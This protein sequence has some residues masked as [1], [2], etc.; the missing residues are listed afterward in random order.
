[1][2]VETHK[3]GPGSL[4][5]GVGATEYSQQLRALSV[6]PSEN[7]TEEEDLEVLSGDTI[8]GED[9][10][11]H[12]AELSGKMLQDL[13]ADGFVAYSWANRGQ[14]VPFTYTPKS[15]VDAEVT[16]MVRLVPITIGGDVK[17][18]MESDFSWQCVGF[19][20]FTPAPA[21]GP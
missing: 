7:V 10:V 6:V 18:R 17:A 5:L 3:L 2:A 12:A 14:V 20:T 21:P 19:P 4:T 9:N 11:T 1:M 16:G 15:A 13:G 8:P